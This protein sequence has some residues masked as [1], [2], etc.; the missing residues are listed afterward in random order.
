ME[1]IGQMVVVDVLGGAG[2]FIRTFLAA[3]ACA[4]TRHGYVS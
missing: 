3:G 4:N 1:V 2:E